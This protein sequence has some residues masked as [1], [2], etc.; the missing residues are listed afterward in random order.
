MRFTKT[1]I[2]GALLVDLDMI[3]DE[4]GFFSRIYCQRE[5]QS[6][7]IDDGIV[8]ANLSYN[9]HA[10]TLRGMHYQIDPAREGKFVR[11]IRGAIQDV[12]VDL[13]PES[14]IYRLS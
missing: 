10:G 4:R 7:Q 5:F 3:T 2:E 11:C 13:R 6:Q 9:L 12:I 14:P 8:Q 1:T